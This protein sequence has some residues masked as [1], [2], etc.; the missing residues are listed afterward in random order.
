MKVEH[1]VEKNV[2]VI[3][4]QGDIAL[5]ADVEVQKYIKPLLEDKNLIGVVVNM[6]E[7]ETIDSSGIGLTISLYKQLKETQV[8]FILCQLREYVLEAYTLTGLNSVLTIL[9]TEE[10]AIASLEPS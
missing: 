9:P 2:C 1:R 8:K 5:G 10:E 3:K 4:L 7:V 6:R